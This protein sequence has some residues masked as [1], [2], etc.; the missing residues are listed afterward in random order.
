[1]DELRVLWSSVN[2]T[3]SEG[4]SDQ[5][6]LNTVHTIQL[7]KLGAHN[8]PSTWE[9]LAKI[10][11]NIEI[12][13]TDAR[14]LTALS[15][16][17]HS[18]MWTWFNKHVT[19]PTQY[20]TTIPISSSQDVEPSTIPNNWIFPLVQSVRLS[21]LIGKAITL[22]PKCFFP[23]LHGAP[24]YTA[25][26]GSGLMATRIIHHVEAAVVLWLQFRPR[27]GMCLDTSRAVATFTSITR[28]IFKSSNFLY[29][30]YIQIA[31][32]KLRSTLT[33]EKIPLMKVPWEKLASEL[34]NH[35]LAHQDSRES[36]IL[37][38][39]SELLW[40]ISNLPH[41]H[42][43]DMSLQYKKAVEVGGNAGVEIFAKS[44]SQL[45]QR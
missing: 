37:D 31:V 38:H 21:L 11:A 39:L 8:I 4:H 13:P 1:M 26:P 34:E 19:E 32:K 16:E 33:E 41:P 24:N 27:P 28:R 29:L 22:E 7:G 43:T 5:A 2:T 36:L 40:A 15:L 3:I 42:P 6:S 25:P 30:N 45:L 44:M 17:S 10:D 20:L 23:D 12:R 14:I 18:E 35:P 9:N